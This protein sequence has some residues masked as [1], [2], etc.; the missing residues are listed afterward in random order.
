M[1]PRLLAI[2]CALVLLGA[3]VPPE[4]SNDKVKR[5]DPEEN[6]M[7]QIQARGEMRIGIPSDRPPFA[8]VEAGAEPRG[9]LVDLGTLAAE[10]LGVEP[11]FVPAP[12]D[13]LLD[14]VYGWAPPIT[15]GGAEECTGETSEAD[16]VF[17]LVPITEELITTYT[18]TDPFWVGHTRSLVATG[19]A[20]GMGPEVAIGPDVE[21][22]A[23]AYEDPRVKVGGEEQS[24]EGYGA[25]SRCGTTTFGAVMSQVI[26]EADAEGDWTASYEMWLAELFVEPAPDAVPIMTVED[27]AALY[28]AELD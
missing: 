14:L 19:R 15:G 24:T 20:G 3:C 16:L 12:N 8:I 10:A 13:D 28:P 7:G 6:V 26:N 5:Y 11:E 4:E 25:A 1:L 22:L 18:F 17:P 21:L 2:A 9:F 23:K 27:A